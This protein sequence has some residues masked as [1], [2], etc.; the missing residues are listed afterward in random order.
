MEEMY[1]YEFSS[2]VEH[3]TSH[4]VIRIVENP[5]FWQRLIILFRDLQN[6]T[7]RPYCASYTISRYYYIF[8]NVNTIT[9]ISIISVINNIKV[10]DAAF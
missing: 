5:S 10:N 4:L 8:V 3:E 7:C 1:R 2:A 9:F 6:C